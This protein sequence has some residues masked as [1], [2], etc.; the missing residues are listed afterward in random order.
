MRKKTITSLAAVLAG[1]LLLVWG[2]PGPAEGN[3]TTDTQRRLWIGA[4]ASK[5]IPGKEALDH[6]LAVF[7]EANRVLG[8]LRY[9]R[10][11]NETL[12][13]SF[14]ESC[15]K[16]DW[17]HG[18]RSFVSWKPPHLDH[19]GAA[20]GVYDAQV[21]SW[22]K[23]VPTSIGLYATVWHEPENDLTGPQYVAMYQHIYSV[24]KAANP[25]I[26]FGPVYM[27]YRWQE[28]T[29]HYAEGGPNAWWVWDRYA[30]FAAVDAYSRNPTTLKS[31]PKFQ[32]WLNFINAKAPT[33]P[34]VVAEY[35][36]C[37]NSPDNP[38]TAEE[39]AVRARIIPMDEA[40]LRSMRFTM[41]LVWHGVGKQVDPVEDLDWRLT[42]PEAQGAWR[43]VASHGR[44]S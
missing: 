8:P 32:G 7:D 26:T 31:N 4:N 1:C 27:A 13:A 18:Y 12:P 28:G 43:T 17:S 10:C 19:A 36:Q 15:A 40:Y 16:D 22:A 11:F 6:S 34:L 39:K 42:D 20:A 2:V 21:R 33:K 30:D 44:A 23:S 41:W 14:Q 25:S 35:G 37:S 38:C 24:V 29:D 9:R 3:A 5:P